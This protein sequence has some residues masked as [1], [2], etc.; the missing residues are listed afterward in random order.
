[1]GSQS[2]LSIYFSIGC[3]LAIAASKFVAAA[4]TGSSAMLSEGIHSVV[5]S[6]NGVL[7]LW[8]KRASGKAPDADH[9]FGYGM[10]LYFWTFV[11]TV[12]IFGMGGGVSIYEGVQRLLHLSPMQDI[13]WSYA[14]LAFSAV[15]EG[16]TIRVAMREFKDI[17]V[18]GGFWNALRVAK[19]LTVLTVLLENAA[20]LLGLAIAF[21]G[22][23]LGNL[24]HMPC[25]DGVASILV[26]VMLAA[27]AVVLATETKGLLIGEGVAKD[28][29]QKIR[30]IAEREAGVVRAGAPLT[31]YFGPQSVLLALDVEFDKRLTAAE[32]TSAVDR[33][34]KN[35]RNQY[36]KIERI[37]I[38]AE[39]L[40]K[41]RGEGSA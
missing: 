3:D 28:V 7:L 17:N 8:G 31:M 23:F 29:L 2:G 19:D 25:L 9:P 26:G 39:S 18:Q 37:F 24:L 4:F 38:E 11:V 21:A 36:P 22:I 27:V 6:C 35:I 34:E 33:L 16:A 32:V 10:E 1:V 15:F 20:A 41:S 14:V 5:D 30:Q 12:L 40:S 13:G